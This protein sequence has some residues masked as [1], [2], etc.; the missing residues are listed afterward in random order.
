MKVA[1]TILIVAQI[2]GQRENRVQIIKSMH[3]ST[4][5][6]TMGCTQDT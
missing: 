1:A 4:D 6:K 3:S 5:F 2:S